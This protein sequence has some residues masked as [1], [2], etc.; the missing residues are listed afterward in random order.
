MYPLRKCEYAFAVLYVSQQRL[1]QHLLNIPPEP[2]LDG[3]E[4]LHLNPISA[5]ISQCPQIIACSI[6]GHIRR[7]QRRRPRLNIFQRL[8][9][10]SGFGSLCSHWEMYPPYYALLSIG[11]SQSH[12]RPGGLDFANTSLDGH[13][14][15]TETENN[16]NCN[17]RSR[18][19]CHSHRCYSHLLPST[20]F[21]SL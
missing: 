4:I 14:A 10:H 18:G 2:C 17:L 11:A 16:P 1:W 6:L 3:T 7:S 5:P 19:L 13:A 15:A 9:M 12:Y 8:S 21:G 20:I